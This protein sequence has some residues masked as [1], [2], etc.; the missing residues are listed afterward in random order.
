MS[1]ALNRLKVLIAL[2]DKPMHSSQIG[3]KLGFNRPYS[4][5]YLTLLA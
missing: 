2:L 1:G 5:I 3:D 4:A